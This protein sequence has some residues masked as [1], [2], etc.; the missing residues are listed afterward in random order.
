MEFFKRNSLLILMCLYT[1]IS[2]IILINFNG[3]GGEGD[4]INHYLFARYAPQHPELFFHHWAKPLFVLLSCPFAQFGFIG[5]KVFNFIVSLLII[6][7]TYLICKEMKIKQAIVASFILMSTPA[8]IILT[9][10]GFTEPLFALFLVAGIL[11]ILRKQFFWAAVLVSFMPF[12]RSE[13]LIIVGVFGLYYLVKKEWKVLPLLSLGHI[14]YSIIGWPVH[15]DLFW[16]ITKI[17][18]ATMDSVYGQGNN[19]FHFVEQLF[20]MTGV[21]VFILFIVGFIR[22][23]WDAIKRN[24]TKE[25]NIIIQ[26]GF[27]SFFIAHSLFWYLG[28]FN[29]MGLKRVL[30]AVFPLVAVI[31]AKGF[32]TITADLPLKNRMI[33]KIA[34]VV[35]IVGMIGIIFTSDPSGIKVE[36]LSRKPEENMAFIVADK[37]KPLINDTTTVYHSSPIV[38][39]ALNIDPFN[40]GI[41]QGINSQMS[42][43]KK[44]DIIIWESWFAVVE[45]GVDLNLLINRNDLEL[46]HEEKG[47]GFHYAVFVKR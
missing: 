44:G 9:Y 30:I 25:Y 40:A 36:D 11:L 47:D 37:I 4:S 24:N 18:Y 12:I 14:I 20:F 10:T 38:S 7:G 15:G 21:L 34:G 39:E 29:S 23:V 26:L 45:A 42:N 46:I 32:N 28:I 16:V 13:G 41:C 5:V 43:I 33:S 27:W 1:I 22:S 3:T 8:F 35:F 19:L 17:P 31:A 2:I 6:V